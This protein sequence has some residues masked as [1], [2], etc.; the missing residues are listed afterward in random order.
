MKY[1]KLFENFDQTKIDKIC[2]KYGIE[3]Y[4]INPDGSIDVDGD[5]D[6]TEWNLTKLPLKFNKVSGSFLCYDNYLTSLDGCPKEVVGNFYC[7]KNNLT[8]LDGCP[9][10]IG[11]GFDL[12]GNNIKSLVGCPREIGGFFNCQ[13]NGLT[14]LEGCPREIGGFFGCSDNYLTSLVGSPKYATS[15]YCNNNELTTLEGC[16]NTG[17][18]DCD[19]NPICSITSLFR[20]TGAYL[21]YQETY[22]FVRKDC[23]IVRHLLEEA[24]KDYNEYYKDNK[25]MRKEI[26]G[27]TYI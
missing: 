8:S 25:R 14:N 4:T 11:G 2:K 19:G 20:S 12:Y 9:S 6:L 17:Y 10:Y 21:E 7:S 26:K 18:I 3:N 5:V 1:L 27:Y 15:V 23:K 16:P 22:N 13:Q 24:L